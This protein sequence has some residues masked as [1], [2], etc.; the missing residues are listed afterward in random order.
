VHEVGV[1]MAISSPRSFQYTRRRTVNAD[2][3]PK[4]DCFSW[5]ST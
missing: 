1:Q 4:R 5:M 3:P 2:R